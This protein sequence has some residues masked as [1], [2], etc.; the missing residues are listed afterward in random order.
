M[1]GRVHIIIGSLYLFFEFPGIASK[2]WK[3]KGRLER[4]DMVICN[5]I[6]FKRKVGR[7]R[8]L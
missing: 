7:E 8:K 1:V 2:E 5:S 6:E 3:N 4:G